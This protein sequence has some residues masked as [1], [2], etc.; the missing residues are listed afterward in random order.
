MPGEDVK[1][2]DPH[3]ASFVGELW[4]MNASDFSLEI[5]IS[6]ELAES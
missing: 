3:W 6:L 2:L 5:L 4:E 1:I